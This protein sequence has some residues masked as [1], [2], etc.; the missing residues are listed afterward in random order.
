[1]KNNEN[2]LLD[3]IKLMNIKIS[4][5]EDIEADNRELL[6]KV[7]KQGNQIVEFLKGCDVQL[8][9]DFDDIPFSGEEKDVNNYKKLSELFYE[10]M[11]KNKDLKEFEKEL[12][13]HKD[14]LTPGQV[15]DA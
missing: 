2:A 11:Q 5:L 8:E 13:K 14:M 9:D 12:K 6:V 10:F 1:M 15:G 3:I 4:H 7:I